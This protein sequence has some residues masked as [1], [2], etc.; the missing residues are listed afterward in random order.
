M[1]LEQ[2]NSRASS[3]WSDS[4]TASWD[5]DPLLM[6][7]DDPLTP[8]LQ[9]DQLSPPPVDT[10][11]LVDEEEEWVKPPLFSRDSLFQLARQLSPV[12]VPLPFAL[13]VFLFTLPSDLK[14]SPHIP[15]VILALVLLALVVIQGTFLYYAGSNDSLWTL[16]TVLGYVA[17]LLV[18]AFAIFG[19]GG[20]LLLFIILL[21]IGFILGGRAIR[22]VPEGH[23]DLVFSFS[24]YQR[25][26][27]PGLNF[28]LPWEKIQGRLNTQETTWTSPAVRVNISRDQDVEIVATL[29]Y[30]LVPEDAHMAIL[31]MKNWEETLHQ[32][33]I[34]TMKSMVKELSPS[35]FVAWSHHVND[36]AAGIEVDPFIDATSMTRWDRFNVML[37]R[38]L[39]DQMA[40]RGI[41]VNLVHIQDITVI[42]HLAPVS[43]PPPGM[44]SRP[45]EAMP[46]DTG[47]AR[48]ASQL[49]RPAASYPVA[50]PAAAPAPLPPVSLP[51]PKPDV[52]DAM[53]D[54][55]NS[56][57]EGR[58]TDTTV[59]LDLAARF[60]AIASH[61]EISQQF[62]WDSAR[63]ASN[64]YQRA[65]ALKTAE[66]QQTSEPD[67]TTEMKRPARRPMNENLA[68]GG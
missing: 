62:N 39:Q 8:P 38:R 23:A 56:V 51:P 28:I 64:L 5:S 36:R 21:V 61:P 53:I 45:A 12:L 59:I 14:S 42:P 43:S 37:R 22:Q 16:Y 24:S 65:Q 58:V 25:T 11:A 41:L 27:F 32:H 63:A 47:V 68:A 17:F 60:N 48:G 40:M 31:N 20:A 52:F 33:F 3:S 66:A 1:T 6:N 13:L 7:L 26:L 35:D 49:P 55:Y 46:V 50:A 30:Q 44:Q 54:M 4:N 67:V 15:V 9:D 18:G 34:G 57:R 29:T 2:D 19:L 10:S